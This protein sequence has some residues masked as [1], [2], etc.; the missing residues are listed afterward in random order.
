MSDY[1]FTNLIRGT[2]TGDELIPSLIFA[3]ITFSLNNQVTTGTYEYFGKYR[4]KPYAKLR[5]RIKHVVDDSFESIAKGEC[6]SLYKYLTQSHRRYARILVKELKGFNECRFSGDSAF[7][8]INT[9]T[10]HV[11]V[12]SSPGDINKVW[13]QEVKVK[14]DTKIVTLDSIL[15]FYSRYYCFHFFRKNFFAIF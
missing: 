13:S 9:A 11:D 8:D 4:Q 12:I 1:I 3:N 5:E 7:D 10:G 15:S 2:E 6:F 14:G